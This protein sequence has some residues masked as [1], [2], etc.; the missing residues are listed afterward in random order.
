[1]VFFGLGYVFVIL[2]VI[3]GFVFNIGNIVGVGFGLNVIMGIFLIVGVVISVVIVVLI[4]VVKE[5][6]KVMDCFM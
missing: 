2:I 5:V 4:F 6:G 3:G 1:M